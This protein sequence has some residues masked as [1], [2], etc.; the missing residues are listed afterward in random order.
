MTA[1]IWNPAQESVEEEDLLARI[2]ALKYAGQSPLFD[3]SG[4]LLS[5]IS[6]AI[7]ASPRARAAPQY[8]ALG[9]WLRAAAL[10][11]M[12]ADF[13]AKHLSENGSL[14]VPRGLA[15]HLPPTNVDTI[16]VYS[17]ALSVLAGNANIVRLSESLSA[18]TEWLV[19][20]IATVVA[21]S[22]ESERH[23]FCSYSYGG[24]FEKKLSRQCDLRM[25]WGGDAKIET[26]SQIPIRPDGLSVGFPDRKSMA[27][28]SAEEYNKAPAETRELLATNLFNDIYWFDQMGCGSP[29]LLVWI[30]D[31]IDKSKDLYQRILSIAEGKNQTVEAGVAIGKIAFA[32]DLLAESIG[33]SACHYS[34]LLEV[35]DVIDPAL[36]LERTQGGGFLMQ[37]NVEK[38]EDVAA[39]TSRRIQTLTHFG[40][41]EAALNR[42]AQSIS[43]R[44]GYRIVPIGQALQFDKIWDGVEL[45]T[46]MTRRVIIRLN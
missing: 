10:K 29:R 32:N 18:D 28:I 19:D 42:L 6:K 36:A 7:L 4:K 9:Y 31:G 26:V 37:T 20:L 34:N 41:S 13:S 33:T 22:E 8:V 23:V 2:E 16:F 44:G 5:K 17:W 21:Q 46:H 1:V 38:I 45:F 40:F 39:F 15:L 11:R 12:V 24:E 3:S 35:T 25:I 14:L 43:G 30:G 27:L